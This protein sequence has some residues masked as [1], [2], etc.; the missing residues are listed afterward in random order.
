[1]SRTPKPA[2]AIYSPTFLTTSMTFIYRQTIGVSNWFQPIILTSK[3]DNPN[4]FPF[5]PI[6][7]KSGIVGVT[8][9]V[10]SKLYRFLS[11]K[12][13][14][15]TRSQL[16]YWYNACYDHNVRLIH[17]QFGYG[18]LQ[19]LPLA[20]S[21]SVPLVVSFRGVDASQLLVNKTYIKNLQELFMYSNVI[22]VSESIAK[23]LSQIGANPTKLHVHYNGVPIEDFT[24]LARQIVP[25]KIKFLQVANFV[26]K[27]GHKYTIE[28]FHRFLAIY[29][30]SHLTLAGDGLLRCE[31]ESLCHMKG[32]SKNVTF[33]GKVNTS[34][35]TQL[36]H[37]SDVFVHH[38]I[39]TEKG[40]K[41]GI[42][43]VLAEAM[44]TG[45]PIISTYHAGIPELIDDG[46]QGFLVPEY[47]VDTYVNRMVDICKLGS[48]M[49]IQGRKKIEDKFNLSKQ[50]VILAELYK[51]IL[52][53]E[54]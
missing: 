54:N 44:S 31:I 2:I 7:E 39:T 36:M 3:R 21:L 4:Q 5:S 27:K 15:I 43:N 22:C 45:L 17:A 20:K 32:I 23:R 9:R 30:N 37:Q 41:E 50:N 40:D 26:E 18:G 12:Y 35:V 53:N 8:G 48:Q 16:K 6:Y 13:T 34:Q 11:Q 10:Y 24:F 33:T 46:I 25:D 19:V 38:S 52:K 42:P 29:P 28:A 49:G 1:M 51:N 47:D 14:F